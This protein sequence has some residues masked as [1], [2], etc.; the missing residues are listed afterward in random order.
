[1]EIKATS[2]VKELK[3]YFFSKF[4]ENI[5]LHTPKGNLAG[6][7]RKLRALTN[8]KNEKLPAHLNSHD[9]VELLEEIR[10]RF[11][12]DIQK[13]KT[14]K[15]SFS[16]PLKIDIDLTPRALGLKI[17]FLLNSSKFEGLQELTNE[18]Q[19]FTKKNPYSNWM[20][21]MIFIKLKNRKRC[22]VSNTILNEVIEFQRKRELAHFDFPLLIEENDFSENSQDIEWEDNEIWETGKFF[23]LL[24]NRAAMDY[25]IDFT[26]LNTGFNF[27]I[28]RN[29]AL[30]FLWQSTLHFIQSNAKNHNSAELSNGIARMFW[31]ILEFEKEEYENYYEYRNLIPIQISEMI[32]IDAFDNGYFDA[33]ENKEM[34]KYGDFNNDWLAISSML[35]EKY[36]DLDGFI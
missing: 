34:K 36:Y 1:M 11:G 15:K 19:S 26:E 30:T 14:S 24:M 9:F 22:E 10:K 5:I 25:K 28:V 2:T 13:V 33:E 4:N 32:D 18:I 29:I 31:T 8:P 7:S 27:D 6:D 12:I 20:I 23:P 35:V 21:S 17:D 16:S 3:D